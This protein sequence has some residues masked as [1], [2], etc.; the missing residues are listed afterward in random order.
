MV[1]EIIEPFM[2]RKRE[3]IE[4]LRESEEKVDYLEGEISDFLSRITRQSIP[5]ADVDEAFQ[6]MYCVTELEQIA[7]IIS[8]NLLPRARGW[9]AGDVQFSEAGKKEIE[10]Y[11]LSA[12]KQVSRALSAFRE[13]DLQTARRM[14]KKYK[15][16]RQMGE[17]FMRTHF[18]RL[19]E[20][21]ADTK[22]T[23]EFH[24]DLVEQ[25]RR[26]SSHATNI[27]RI[28]IEWSGEEDETRSQGR[29]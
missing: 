8:K 10:E 9:L 14:K 20:D 16:Y 11:H 5:E 4:D 12:V 19:R 21:I 17:S 2:H 25:F 15:K 27:A 26:I 28:L 23:R 3:V 13:S 6:M 1:V 24:Q 18:E 7:D 22:A 29:Q